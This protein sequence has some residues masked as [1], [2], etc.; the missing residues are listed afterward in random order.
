MQTLTIKGEEFVVIPRKDFE[1]LKTR[2]G[3]AQ[4]ALPPLPKPDADGNVPA[5]AYTRALIARR[6][7]QARRQAGWS[8]SRLA[9]ESGVRAETISR[10]ENC[11]HS[12]DPSSV[13]KLDR[14]FRRFKVAL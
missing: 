12:A 14:A 13:D 5:V 8:Q 6:L 11:R 3:E 9:K 1:R 7:I 4:A 10:I 2:A